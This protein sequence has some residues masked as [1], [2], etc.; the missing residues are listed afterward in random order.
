VAAA[1]KTVAKKRPHRSG[2]KFGVR[3]R[4]GFPPQQ[5]NSGTRDAVSVTTI[6]ISTCDFWATNKHTSWR[7]IGFKDFWR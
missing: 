2:A 4:E 6:R 1:V 3:G 7:R 5:R